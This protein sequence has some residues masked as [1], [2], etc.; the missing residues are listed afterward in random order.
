M[1]KKKDRM[2]SSVRFCPVCGSKCILIK[3][4]KKLFQ[5]KITQ[6]IFCHNC[7]HKTGFI[8]TEIIDIERWKK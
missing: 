8:P 7:E 4:K 5:K 3:Y 6:Y 1:S 2:F